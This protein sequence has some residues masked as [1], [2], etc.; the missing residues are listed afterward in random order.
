MKKFLTLIALALF[1]SMNALADSRMPPA[2]FNGHMNLWFIDKTFGTLSAYPNG[3]LAIAISGGLQ[4]IVFGANVYEIPSNYGIRII[5]NKNLLDDSNSC[6]NL[7]SQKVSIDKILKSLQPSYRG[8]GFI[9]N[10]VAPISINT[11]I[12]T[13]SVTMVLKPTNSRLIKS[14]NTRAIQCGLVGSN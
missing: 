8:N 9:L 6:L 1:G 14:A 4:D 13:D 3:D 2:T 5:I 7:L 10:T 12:F 11:T